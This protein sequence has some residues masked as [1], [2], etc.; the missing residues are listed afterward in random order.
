MVWADILEEFAQYCK[1]GAIIGL[2]SGLSLTSREQGL[3]LSGKECIIIQGI[4]KNIENNSP[5]TNINVGDISY[6]YTNV[7]KGN[8]TIYY[9][10]NEDKLVILYTRMLIFTML[11]DKNQ[12][13]D[14]DKIKFLHKDFIDKGM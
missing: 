11:F 7:D 10:N 13:N 9:E 8:K 14:L 12:T 5:D 3:R 1:C 2:E 4:C 6:R